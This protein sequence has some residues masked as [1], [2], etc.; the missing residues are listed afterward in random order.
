M[1]DLTERHFA[2]GQQQTTIQGPTSGKLNFQEQPAIIVT[3]IPDGFQPS[4]NT[5]MGFEVKDIVTTLGGILG[6]GGIGA[7]IGKI[8]AKKNEEKIEQTKE[9]VK[10]TKA[11]V[12]TTK[13]ANKDLAKFTFEANKEKAD[14]LNGT[15]PNIKIKT[16]E[17]DIKA[18][19]D[20]NAKT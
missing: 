5:L 14:A 8:F 20:R 13:I 4:Q 16:L 3:K 7:G 12:L 17:D 1:A 10:D 2:F 18:T 11:D 15:M 6:G 9:D 19:A